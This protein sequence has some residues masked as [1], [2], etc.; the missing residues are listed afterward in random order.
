[1]PAPDPGIFSLPGGRPARWPP[2]FAV[3]LPLA[4]GLLALLPDFG[5]PFS[6][7]DDG[8]FLERSDTVSRR[9]AS[10]DWRG[11]WELL[12]RPDDNRFGPGL[13]LQIW[14]AWVL[15]GES[16]LPWR[17]LKAMNLAFVL[18]AV[19]QL[20]RLAGG[21]RGAAVVAALSLVLL[22][23]TSVF[24]DI[25]THLANWRRLHTTD[26]HVIPFVAWQAVF[27]V[28]AMD[29]RS[30]P[31][32]RAGWMAALAGTT[33][34][35]GMTK[36]TAVAPTAAC[37][38]AAGM[39]AGLRPRDFPWR[40]SAVS[41]ALLAG[42][43]LPGLLFFRPWAGPD[44]YYY[45][46]P[47]S[48]DPQVLWASF[49]FTAATFV[50]GWG[51]WILPAGLLAL[52]VSVRGAWSR[53]GDPAS[54]LAWITVPGVA[55][56]AYLLQSMWPITIPRYAVTYSP[57]VAV[58]WGLAAWR[59][60]AAVAG[61]LG[62]NGF[63]RPW[64]VLAIAGFAGAVVWT[65]ATM[66]LFLWPRVT[67]ARWLPVG[68][69]VLA[70][71]V[72]FVVA[73]RGGVAMAARRAGSVAAAGSAVGLLAAQ[74]VILVNTW[75]DAG[76]HY[77][78]REVA[79]RPLADY[80]AT[81]SNPDNPVLVITNETSEHFTQANALLRLWG[82][83]GGVRFVFHDW[84]DRPGE[85]G[86]RLLTFWSENHVGMRV[87]PPVIGGWEAVPLTATDEAFEAVVIL[88]A[89]NPLERVYD[90]DG[91]AVISGYE[92]R[93]DTLSWPA[94]TDIE[95]VIRSPGGESRRIVVPGRSTPRARTNRLLVPVD[96]PLP[97]GPG[98]VAVTL[99]IIPGEGGGSIGRYLAA[100]AR[101]GF[102]GVKSG[103]GAV[104]HGALLGSR[105]GRPAWE[106][107][108]EWVF[109]DDSW[110]LFPPGSVVNGYLFTVGPRGW[111]PPGFRPIRYRTVVRSYIRVGAVDADGATAGV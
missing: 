106:L 17:L 27:L 62:S 104:P 34:V 110:V 102:P 53:G 83:A 71:P 57:F 84:L 97:S 75:R 29:P 93:A 105:A 45:D 25:Q 11:A 50:E 22:E 91:P 12:Y 61:W 98:P 77:R 48:L 37:A 24:P 51:P 43:I 100:R 111:L 36:V 16:P 54:W 3:G 78:H 99:A 85:P 49:T 72:G 94:W 39:A 63:E 56:A 80:P 42:T 66:P 15:F 28:L 14:G 79:S 108:R 20:V 69:V 32:A 35:A 41:V 101:I 31:K 96:P 70:M 103:G 109:Q 46:D 55:A 87:V 67:L 13:L 21:G 86:D 2:W 9:L 82:A 68:I 30:G 64:R 5:L 89:A 1:M 90:L 44:V 18:A 33:F 40:R 10:G 23:R 76:I 81:L 92:L 8:L 59:L 60:L 58:L 47:A 19:V 4:L 107:E 7:I 26:S 88:D 74:G 73:W 52:A 38:V 6:L 95:V 65:V